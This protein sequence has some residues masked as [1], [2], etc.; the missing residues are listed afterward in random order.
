MDSIEELIWHGLNDELWLKARRECLPLSGT[1]ELLPLCNFRC[2]MCYVRLDA[3]KVEQFGRIRTGKEWLDLGRQAQ[4]AGVLSLTLSGGEPLLHPDF[5]EIYTGLSQ[6]GFM[7][8]VLSNGS[9]VTDEHLKLFTEYRPTRIRFTLYG[10]SN[11]TYERLCGAPNG[12]DR[13]MS[14]IRRLLDAGM[15]LSLSFTE[16]QENVDDFDDVMAIAKQLDIPL[17]VCTDLDNPVRGAVSDAANLRVPPQNQRLPQDDERLQ[18]ARANHLIKQAQKEGL[19]DGLF[20]D[21]KPYRTSFFVTWNGHMENC[22]SM[23]YCRSAPF[24]D[25]FMAA[26]ADM[27]DKLSRLQLPQPCRTCPSLHFCTACPAKRDAETGRPDGIPRRYCEEAH[28]W[29]QQSFHT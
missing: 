8:S 21:C 17:M 13:V 19:L 6:M 18:T 28:W 12:F 29:Q 10:A 22:G 4:Q 2:R 23:S 1:F 15:P 3:E 16:T 20:S 7:V 24:E 14:S 26:W 5:M 9:L 27:H 25:G 11:E